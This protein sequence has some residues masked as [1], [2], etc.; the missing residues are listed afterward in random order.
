MYLVLKDGSILLSSDGS[1]I[2]SPSDPPDPSCCCCTEVDCLCCGI[3]GG[4][5]EATLS[6]SC[7]PTNVTIT[8]TWTN[9]L[10]IGGGS[11]S[12]QN[13]FEGTWSEGSCSWKLAFYCYDGGYRAYLETPY[14][15]NIVMSDF[16]CGDTTCESIHPG[17]YWSGCY[18]EP[19]C[20]NIT[21][22]ITYDLS[23]MEIDSRYV[24]CC[25]E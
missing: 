8:L 4:S 20:N 18:E 7:G 9:S 23:G 16:A 13:G 5:I 25:G 22:T 24:A 11:L 6:S 17:V 12:A 3:I 10:T 1:I 21:V 2:L 19:E 14:A 15:G